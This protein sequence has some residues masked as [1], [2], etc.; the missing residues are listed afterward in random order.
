M[1][2]IEIARNSIVNKLTLRTSSETASQR[3]ERIQKQMDKLPSVLDN[4]TLTKLKNGD[5]E[6]SLKEYS[7]FNSYRSN[8]NALYGNGS[9]NNFE[10]YLNKTISQ[11]ADFVANAKD[12]IEKMQDNGMSN[13]QA[14]K[15]YSALKS[16]SMISSFKNYNFIS[17]KI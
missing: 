17:A 15:L 14:L 5:Y 8:M 13:K 16:Y 9:A 1:S 2:E 3:F 6:I 4:D 10:N 11:S 7:D 12:F